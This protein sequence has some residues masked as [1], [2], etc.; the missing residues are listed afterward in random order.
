MDGGRVIRDRRT[1]QNRF[2]RGGV[3]L[4]MVALAVLS[5]CVR[6][7]PVAF[8]TEGKPGD[9]TIEPCELETASGSYAADCGG[10]VVSEGRDRGQSRL[11]HLPVQRIRATTGR[12]AEPIFWLAGGPGQSNMQFNPP[13]ELL[14]NHDVVKVGYRGVDGSSVLDCPEVR[15]G[16]KGLGHDLLSSPSIANLR[17]A[18]DRCEARLRATGIDLAAYTI[19]DVVRDMEMA[20][21]AL[22][23]EHVNLLSASYGTRVAQIYARQHPERIHRSIMIAVNPPGRFVW[24][25]EVTDR[26]LEYYARLCAEDPTCSARTPDLVQTMRTVLHDMPRRWLFLPI[27]TGKVRV[28]TFALLF[29]RETAALVFDAY[30][31]AEKGDAS[32]LALMSLAYDFVI[33]SMFTWGDMASKA[34]TADC[35]PTRDYEAEMEPPGSILGAP[36]SKLLW[37][38]LQCSQVALIPEEYRE[39]QRSDVETLLLVGSVDFSTPAEYAAEELLPKLTKGRLIRLAEF[40]HVQDLFSVQRPATRHLLATFYGTGVADDSLF[41]YAPMDFAVSWGFPK[42]AKLALGFLV[43]VISGG[44]GSVWLVRRWVRRRKARAVACL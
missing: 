26:Q 19:P 13:P 2:L 34:V 32:G 28:V 1:G 3:V 39:V 10:L 43:L 7:D 31:A 12:P 5:A 33:P 15:R 44:I 4:L 9:L 27:D 36:L 40:G 17:Q 22:G 35:D 14:A 8:Q 38:S 18:F 29:H 20:R 6:D 11:I 41:T 23:Y 30:V 21:E 37:G 42:I 24:E 16:M 25:P